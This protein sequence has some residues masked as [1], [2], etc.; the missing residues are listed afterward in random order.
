[1]QTL[2]KITYLN[3]LVLVF[4]TCFQLPRVQC[5]SEVTLVKYLPDINQL[6][7]RRVTFGTT[8]EISFNPHHI[9]KWRLVINS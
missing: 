6:Q 7:V 5:L 4:S 9:R 8:Y 2:H 3:F 1:M